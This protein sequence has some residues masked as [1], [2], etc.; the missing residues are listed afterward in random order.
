MNEIEFVYLRIACTV[1]TIIIHISFLVDRSGMVIHIRR[2]ALDFCNKVLVE[3]LS[4]K[5]CKQAHLEFLV[6]KMWNEKEINVSKVTLKQLIVDREITSESLL[7]RFLELGLPLTK[8]DI[9]MAITSLRPT[10]MHLFRYIVAKCNPADLDELCQAA[11][12]SNRMTFVLY[13]VERGA[14]LPSHGSELLIHAL[15]TE[16]YDGAL[17]LAKKFTKATMDKLNL[18]TLMD[19]NIV[20]CPEL[21]KVL[22]DRG[23]SPNGKGRKTPISVVMA[24][25]ISAT[26]KIDMICLLLEIGEDCNHLSNTGKSTTTPLHVATELGL[27]SGEYSYVNVAC[28]SVLTMQ[29]AMHIVCIYA[30][31]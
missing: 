17:A 7:Q 29:T 10:Q 24:K 22:V 5:E 13:L 25:A 11:V 3:I 30:C 21:I 8:E 4:R 14:K 18:A 23:L 12:S 15:K 16:D 20:N 28:G 19:S 27:Q 1:C 9:K 2:M 31:L 6:S 26:K